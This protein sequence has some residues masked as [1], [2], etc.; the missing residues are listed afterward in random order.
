MN[1]NTIPLPAQESSSPLLDSSTLVAFDRFLF[2]FTIASHIILVATSISLIVVISI[3]EFLAIRK[4]DKFY[5]VLSK[6]LS[7]VF[8]ISFG[9]GTASGIVMA[10]ELVTLFPS[11][12]TLVAETG[13]ISLLYGEVFAFLSGNFRACHVCL[14][15]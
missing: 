4:N 3:A 12:M 14:L 7:K 10:V 11:F 13:V 9:V 8:V 6:R 2:A 15:R 1:V 5:G